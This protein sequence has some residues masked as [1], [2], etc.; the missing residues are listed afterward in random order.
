MHLMYHFG[1]MVRRMLEIASIF[2]E[3]FFYM[4]QSDVPVEH[5]DDGLKFL[6]G[7]S[8]DCVIFGFHDRQLKVLLIRFRNTNLWALPGGYIH[9]EEDMDE[10]ASR[11]LEE[12]TAVKNIYL[13][14]FYTFGQ[15]ER[16]D[17]NV[18]R[19]IVEAVG[20][21]LLPTH[22]TTKRFVSVGY[23]ALVDFMEVMPTPDI[24]SDECA[25]HGLDDM[26]DLVFDHSFIVQKALEMLP[27]RL[28]SNLVSSNLLPETFTMQE[29]QS[30]YE[31]IMGKKMLRANF[32]RKMLNLG[33]LKRVEKKFSGRA[34]KAPYLYRF[35]L[36]K[37]GKA[38]FP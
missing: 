11:I 23:Y 2:A 33:V 8:I 12:R 13:E 19:K 34:H 27:L 29:L 3:I 35:D 38:F 5:L 31:T 26:P 16:V 4:K 32:Q 6:P 21:R 22:W 28:G 25:W 36:K 18:Q 10:A 20:R 15:R 7:V 17:I 9:T 37:G 30:L 1:T 24:T 14:Q